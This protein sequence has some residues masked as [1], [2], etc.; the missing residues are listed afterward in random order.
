MRQRKPCRLH[1]AWQ[2]SC[3]KCQANED[4]ALS[5]WMRKATAYAKKINIAAGDDIFGDG[6]PYDLADAAAAAFHDNGDP[7]SFV[8]E[9]FAEDLASRALERDQQR[10]S[11][12]VEPHMTS[13]FELRMTSRDTRRWVAWKKRAATYANEIKI[14]TTGDLFTPEDLYEVNEKAMEAFE[15]NTMSPEDFIRAEFAED[16]AEDDVA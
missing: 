1:R 7:R 11:L 2:E 10:Q 3:K 12:G 4:R 6:D 8:R 14:V 5:T 9:A 13:R 16:I 15:N